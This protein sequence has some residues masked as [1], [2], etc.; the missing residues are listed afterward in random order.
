M[1]EILKIAA[2]AGVVVVAFAKVPFLKKLT[3]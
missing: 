3:A 1:K 2:I